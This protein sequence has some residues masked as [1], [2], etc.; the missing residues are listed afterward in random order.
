MTNRLKELNLRHKKPFWILLL[1][2]GVPAFF[3]MIRIAM[4][5]KTYFF[6]GQ[7]V[8]ESGVPVNDTL[9]YDGIALKPGVYSIELSYETDYDRGA[10]CTLR[11]GTVFTGGLLTN[12]EHFYKNLGKTGFHA[13]LYESTEHMQ[14]VVTYDGGGSLVT[15][16]L[17]VT[18]TNLMWTKLLV[19]LLFGLALALAIMTYYY[20]QQKYEVSSRKKQVFFF[21]AL[22]SLVASLPYLH[23]GVISGADLTYHLLRIEGVK[24][25]LLSGQIPVRIEPGWLY[26]HGYADAI[27]YCN[28][29]LVIPALLRM[30]GFTI[31]SSYCIYC[32]LLNIATAWIAYHCFSRIYESDTIGLVCSGLYTLSVFRIYKLTITSAVGEGSAYVFLPL[33]LYGF[34]RVFSEDRKEK[35]YKTA[36]VPL[37]IGY[38][39]L[40]QTHVLTCEITLFLT[41]VICLIF[42]PRIFHL[43]TFLELAKG[44]LAALGLS[45][46]YLVPFVDYYLT[47]DMH[48]KHASARTIQERGTLPAQLA[49][50][51]WS[52]GDNTPLG[53]NGMQ[54]SHPVGVGFVLALGLFVFAALAINGAYQKIKNSNNNSNNSKK[55]KVGL[56]VVSAIMG[57]LLLV[58]SLNVFPWNAIQNRNGLSAALVSSLQFPNRFLGWGT[59]FLVTVFGYVLWYFANGKR[60]YYRIGILV[61]ILSILSGNMYMLDYVAKDQNHYNLYHEEGMGFGYISGAEYLIEGTDEEKL[62]FDNPVAGPK[63]TILSYEQKALHVKMECRNVGGYSYVTLPLLS[64]KG[65]RAK[66][67]EGR[68]L[69]V[70]DGT[71][72]LLRVQVPAGFAG[73]IRVDFVSP[74]YWRIS[75]IISLATLIGL[76]AAWKFGRKDA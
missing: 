12:G 2:F 76:L 4:P 43:N 40:M 20:Y 48:I 61:A 27:F 18:E 32:I 38:A 51:F 58:M 10:H 63:V 71:N 39:G 26:D 25:G 13:W 29:L 52:T 45:M 53:N 17:K 9:I 65:Y 47:Q 70:T 37:A 24:D 7:T 14:V 55:A 67:G 50:H 57:T 16:D 28:T 60:A 73:E 56:G 49:F 35:K 23:E 1:L 30:A 46:W 3:C 75:E 42:L 54:Y 8:F 66:D 31:L 15:G 36:W 62:T 34:Y 5:N 19:V 33:I 64:Y 74:L 69:V 59:V 22:I 72:H 44:A 41:I 68:R 21:L 6:T 11:D